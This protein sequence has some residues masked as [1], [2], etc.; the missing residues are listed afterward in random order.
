MTTTKT[1]KT[2]RTPKA[3]ADAEKAKP[4]RRTAEQK[5]ADLLAEVERVKEREAAKEMRADPA[6]KLTAQ[7]VRALNKAIGEAEEAGLVEA[8]EAAKGAL[9]GYLEGKGLRVPKPGTKRETREQAT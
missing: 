7:A 3:K 6:M 2:K 9:A 4:K 1:E 5:I 8:L